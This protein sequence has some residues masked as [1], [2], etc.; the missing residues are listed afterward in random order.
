MASQS[1]EKR[2]AHTISEEQPTIHV[3]RNAAIA[4]EL[5][6]NSEASKR[7]SGYLRTTEPIGRGARLLNQR[8]TSGTQKDKLIRIRST[9]HCPTISR[10]K[11]AHRWA[12]S[13]VMS[14]I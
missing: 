10:K 14:G 11:T 6:G 13:I 9:F 7:R 3:T 5:T 8:H 12:A 2:C 4:P 1:R